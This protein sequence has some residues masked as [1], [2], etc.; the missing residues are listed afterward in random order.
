MVPRVG[1]TKVATWQ[2]RKTA[3]KKEAGASREKVKCDEK[4]ENSITG[5]A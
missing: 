1:F 4:G 3:F 5:W 2:T